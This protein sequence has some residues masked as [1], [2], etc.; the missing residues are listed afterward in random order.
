MIMQFWS[1]I[2]APIYGVKW[3]GTRQYKINLSGYNRHHL[4]ILF[5]FFTPSFRIAQ[6]FNESVK[7]IGGRSTLIEGSEKVLTWLWRGSSY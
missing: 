3:D 2:N 1:D 7:A 5:E 4:P 6:A